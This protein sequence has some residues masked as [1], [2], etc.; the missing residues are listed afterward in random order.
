VA[1]RFVTETSVLLLSC[2]SF[3]QLCPLMFHFRC[4]AD[5]F[6]SPSPGHSRS[7]TGNVVAHE[8]DLKALFIVLA[9][10]LDSEALQQL[11]GDEHAAALVH[12]ARNSAKM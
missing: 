2:F 10:N 9:C 6:A 11:Q 8:S 12:A 1:S 3:C 4:R 7:L 5:F